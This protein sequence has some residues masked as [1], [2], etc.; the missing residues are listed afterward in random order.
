V[1]SL[2]HSQRSANGEALQ[3]G[4]PRPAG[5]EPLS[6]G[7]LRASGVQFCF[8]SE[9]KRV[10]LSKPR[11]AGAPDFEMRSGALRGV[12]DGCDGAPCFSAARRP[13]F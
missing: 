13:R 7:P 8:F 1:L 3:S 11:G 6:A 12:P 10:P 4:S 5:S 9:L 2:A